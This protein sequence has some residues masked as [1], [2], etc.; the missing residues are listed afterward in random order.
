MAKKELVSILRKP[1]PD[2]K[3]RQPLRR[4]LEQAEQKLNSQHAKRTG[5]YVG[6]EG[7]DFID[8]KLVKKAGKK[9]DK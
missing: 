3:P 2:G 9:E 4:T 6:V 1:F 8:G 5:C 7:Y